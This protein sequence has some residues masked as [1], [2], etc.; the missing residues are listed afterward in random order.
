MR[1]PRRTAF[2]L[3]RLSPDHYTT[4]PA[5]PGNILDPSIHRRLAEPQGM[6]VVGIRAAPEGHSYA[7]AASTSSLMRR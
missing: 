6:R 7:K 3:R 2:V 4:R 5:F 1:P